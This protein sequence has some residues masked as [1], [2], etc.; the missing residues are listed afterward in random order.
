MASMQQMGIGEVWK[1]MGEVP[2]EG[3]E[4]RIF[5]TSLLV[6]LLLIVYAVFL[7]LK[8]GTLGFYAGLA[9]YL[10]GLAMYLTT[11]VNIASTPLG[12]PWTSAMYRFSRHPMTISGLLA[13]AGPSLAS[14]SWL[15]LLLAI[16]FTVL[17]K[18]QA[19]AEERG[20][21]VTYGDEYRKYLSSTPRWIGLPRSG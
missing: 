6:M 21:L 11:L 3:Y 20:C 2:Y 14:G 1:K 15:L 13:W 10:V 9:M 12:Q 16:V 19:D 17:Q 5:M 4:E 18:A 8:L 7:P